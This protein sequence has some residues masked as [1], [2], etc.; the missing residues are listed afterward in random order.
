MQLITRV[1]YGIAGT[2]MAIGLIW[3]VAMGQRTQSH[4]HQLCLGEPPGE[5]YNLCMMENYTNMVTKLLISH[6]LTPQTVK[7]NSDILRGNQGT[8]AVIVKE[9]ENF[10]KITYTKEGELVNIDH[11]P[12]STI[13]S[14]RFYVYPNK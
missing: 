1:Q 3:S 6:T 13:R 11:F 9:Y 7:C 8:C 4:F 12:G 2:T 5:E 14:G 10:I